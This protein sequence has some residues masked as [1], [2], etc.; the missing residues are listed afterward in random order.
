VEV[1]FGLQPIGLAIKE[2]LMLTK[3]E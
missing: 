1:P 2:S 3:A